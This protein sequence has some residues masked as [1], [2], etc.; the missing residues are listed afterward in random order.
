M[1]LPRSAPATGTAALAGD[2]GV[3]PSP[4]PMRRSM[5]GPGIAA[6]GLLA[7][8]CAAGEA[9]RVRGGVVRGFS[10]RWVDD[11]VWGHCEM[12]V[13][14]LAEGPDTV[15]TDC[16]SEDGPLLRRERKLATTEIEHLRQLLQAAAPFE[17]QSW[18]HD[19]RGLDHALLTLQI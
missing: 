19:L 12:L 7:V 14:V 3:M 13:Q 10:P 17:G 18:G 2:L 1:H 4:E 9:A 8:A 15:T 11:S 16:R 5:Q 6:I